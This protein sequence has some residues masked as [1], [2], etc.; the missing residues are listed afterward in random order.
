[1][2]SGLFG[3]PPLLFAGIPSDAAQIA[4]DG[5]CYRL[6]IDIAFAANLMHSYV[7]PYRAS[8]VSAVMSELTDL[9]AVL[10]G[11]AAAPLS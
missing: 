7:A 4:R 11:K 9:N 8:A 3:V 1:M 6:R 5:G 2:P 10:T